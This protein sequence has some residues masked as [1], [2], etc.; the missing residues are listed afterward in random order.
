MKTTLCFTLTLLILA[1]LTFVPNSLAQTTEPY[2]IVRFIYFVPSNRTPEQGINAKFDKLIKNV[3]TYFADEMERHG[4]GRKTF[5]FEADGAG[6]AVVHRVNGNFPDAHYTTRL[7]PTV[8]EEIGERFD[9][10]K[11]IYFIVVDVSHE[12]RGNF[13]G[14]A[15]E[16][17]NAVGDRGGIVFFASGVCFR[18]HDNQIST[19]AHELGHAFGLHHDFSSDNYL[20]SY[21]DFT[22]VWKTELSQCSAEWLNVNR[23]FNNIHQTPPNRSRT[24]IEMLPPTISPTEG[25]RF[26][27]RVSDPD[28]LQIAHLLT[29]E[30]SEVIG[31]LVGCKN[32]TGQSQTIEFVTTELTTQSKFVTLR[33][34]DSVDNLAQK[35]F[36]IDATN[37]FASNIVSIPDPNLASAIRDALGVRSRNT[38]MQLDML[39]LKK[40]RATDVQ[41][42]DLT[43]LE[44]AK[45][46]KYL[47][48]NSSQV[49]DFTPI[50]ELSNLLTLHLY[51]SSRTRNPIDNINSVPELT[52]LWD[53]ALSGYQFRDL[54]AFAGLPN[55]RYLRL[56]DN[57][58]SDVTPPTGLP[59]LR[60]LYLSNN[61]ISDITPLAGLTN[62]RWLSLWGNQIKDISPLAEVTNLE[63]LYLSGNQISDITPLAGLTNLHYLTLSGNRIRDVSPLA[64]LRNLYTLLLAANPIED[65]SPLRILLANNPDLEIDIDIPFGFTQNLIADQTFVAGTDV[66]LTLPIAA[67]GTAPYTY[68]LSPIP[69]GLQFDRTTRVLSGKPTTASTTN[70]TYTATDA[71]GQTASLTFKI[72]VT[73]TLAFNPSAIADQAFTV[74]EAVNLTLPVA[75]GGTPPYTYTLAPLPEGLSFNAT[76]REMSGKPTTAG[77]TTATYTATDAASVSASLTFTITVQDRPTFNPSAIADQTFTVGEAV[78]LTLPVAIGGTPPYTY[79]LAPLPEGLSFNVIE[80]E[81]SGKPTTAETTTATYT[82]T[83]AANVSASLTFTIEVTEGVILDVN[84]D[85]QVTVIDLAI[86]AL[87]YGTQVPA[88]T[89]LPADVNVDGIV[90]VLDLTAVAQGIDAASDINGLSLVEV[91]AALLA[92]VGQVTELEVIAGAPASFGVTSRDAL[93][94]GIAAKNIAAALADVRQMA[95]GDVRLGKGR[96][97]LEGLLQLL[98]EMVAIPESTAL[99]PNYPNPFNPETWIPYHLSKDADVTLHIYAVNGTLVRTLTLGHQAAGMY[100]NRS[101]AAYWDGRNALGEP[102]SSGV[103]FYRL[104]AGDFTATRKMLIRK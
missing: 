67:S 87:F 19:A 39:A 16:S 42:T 40:L 35:A 72:T 32:L 6:N 44:Y 7:S 20:M 81:L 4:F 3:Q 49:S 14:Y 88:D 94:G 83:D 80:R 18:G 97:V 46:L 75:T 60:G 23:Y 47:Y 17:L 1:T 15:G 92:A 21:G 85:G 27:F 62:L 48:L 8:T 50:L 54:T 53:L 66:S 70:M 57:Q 12:L 65:F 69:A 102:V 37:F 95:V 82:A 22:G 25:V 10:F 58:I 86:V 63:T 84:G 30:I 89:R 103:Y 52:Q 71:T 73:G 104:T 45:N 9:I 59:N 101:R 33:I 36:P 56:F 98:A 78:S 76:Q 11:N 34:L 2:N 79:T 5:A 26:R 93:S 74:G 51:N 68:T 24:R 28:G 13:C 38:I 90:N 31:G 77:T 43:G 91:E 100:Q 41:I 96:A 61:Q 55:L 99:L 29:P 64:E